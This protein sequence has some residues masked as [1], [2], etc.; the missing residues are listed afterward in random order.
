MKGFSVLVLLVYFTTINGQ[1]K[2]FGKYHNE[3]GETLTLNSDKTFDYTWRFDLASS[4]NTGTWKVK[5][6]KYLY[7]KINEI[8]DTL[9][10][11]NKIE[12]VLS[13]DRKSNEATND[14]K[15]INA[16][17]GGGQSRHLPP[18]KLLLDN[19][20]L[21]PYSKTG[22]LQDK[23]LQSLMNGNSFSKPWFEKIPEKE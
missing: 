9:K 3:F 15:I 2:V 6:G 13:I 23:K 14:Q 10:T 22:E 8:K 18:K 5:K 1:K 17:S 4:W 12:L 19:Q 16:L 20:K 21:F 11:Q 7:L